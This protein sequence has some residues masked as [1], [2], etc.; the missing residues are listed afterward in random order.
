MMAKEMAMKG[1]VCAC[2]HHSWFA[3]IF[4]IVGILY[5]LQDLA[6]ISFWNWLSWYTVLFIL[7][8]LGMMCKC[9]SKGK[10]F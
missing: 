5:L 8:G 2:P 3:W 6:V 9:C 1:E 7:L 4:L 10:C